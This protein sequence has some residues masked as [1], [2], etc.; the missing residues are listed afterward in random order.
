METYKKALQWSKDMG[1][2]YADLR[3]IEDRR[4]R[5]GVKNGQVDV[6]DFE[7]EKGVALRVRVDGGWGFAAVNLHSDTEPDLRGLVQEAVN[8]AKASSA[9]QTQSWEMGLVEPVQAS[10]KVVVQEDPFTVPVQERLALLQSAVKSMGDDTRIILARGNMEMRHE[11]KV[12]FSTEGSEIEQET[13]MTG[14]GISA[15]ASDGKD[16]QIRSYPSTFGGNFAQK[17]YEWIRDMNLEETA[18]EV[19]EEAL[20]L[21]EAPQC[22]SATMTLILG[23]SQL[24]LQVH[25][26]VGHPIELDRVY[27]TEAGFAG[28][29]FLTPDTLGRLQFGASCVNL[30]ADATIPGALGSFA[31]DDEGVAAQR[32][33]IVKDGLFTGY[34]TSRET[35]ARLGQRSNGTMRAMGWRYLPIIRMTNINLEPGDSSLDELIAGTEN[36]VLMDTIKSWSIDDKRM[37]FQ[38]GTE[39][40]W[41]IKDGA[42]Q[43][44]VKNPTYTGSTVPF[45]NSCDGIA[46]EKEWKLYGVPNCGK[47][48]PTQ[49]ATVGHGVSYARFRNIKVGVG[50]W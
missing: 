31:Y 18:P 21:L 45:W 34:L 20:A 23:G 13:T 5:L 37:N 16:R 32:I 41:L 11:K 39:A 2:Q 3:Y 4:D 14:A 44:L 22:P 10:H 8:I 48:E 42:I 50:K 40:G 33:E 12:F 27:G 24:A 7:K 25:E 35:A 30:T 19:A 1:A 28:T 26:S 9:V 43:G 46:D 6:L 38:F 49:A 17:G 29:S 36:G 47:G 15:M